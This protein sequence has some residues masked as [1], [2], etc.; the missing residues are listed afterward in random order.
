MDSNQVDMAEYFGLLGD[1]VRLLILSQLAERPHNVGDL[2]EAAGVS[3]PTASHHLGKLRAAF[4][5][6][7][8]RDGR[9][10]IYSTNPEIL[11]DMRSY[12]LYLCGEDTRQAPIPEVV[13]NEE[14]DIPEVNGQGS[15]S[16]LRDAVPEE[17]EPKTTASCETLEVRLAGVAD[18]EPGIETQS[19]ASETPEPTDTEGEGEG[20]GSGLARLGGL[21]D[22]EDAAHEH[23]PIPDNV[24]WLRKAIG[25]LVVGGVYLLGG[26]PGIGKST[27]ALQ[28][29]LG[30]GLRDEHSL[31]IL[32]EQSAGEVGKRA[33]HLTKGWQ[34]EDQTRA[35]QAV[36]PEEGVYSL[37]ALPDFLVHQILSPNGKY[38]G[39]RLVVVDSVQG[40]GISSRSTKTY[41]HVYEFSR[42]C[43]GAGI[44]VV[45]VCHVTKAGQIAGPKGLEHN[46]DCVVVMRKAMSYRPLFVPKNRFGPAVLQPLLLEMSRDTGALRES[47]HAES[48]STA[49]R[50]FLTKDAPAL[51]E[52]QAAVSLPAYGSRGKIIA[53]G[54]P[55]KEIEQIVSCVNQLPDMSLD[56][57][58]Y[59]LNCR[60][61][62]DGIYRSTLG[63]PLA[64]ALIAS[65]IQQSIPRRNLYIGEIDLLRHVRQAP[66]R[67]IDELLALLND[68]EDPLP[69]RVFLPQAD[70]QRVLQEMP[71]GK[72]DIVGCAQ[73]EDAVYS[74]WPDLK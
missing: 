73:L 29:G 1:E 45:L 37:E 28:L 57:L 14:P 18:A 34:K 17:D 6:K 56:D 16:L 13:Q 24:S 46:V 10:V 39:V 33:R 51:P 59:S 50:S 36:L 70:A 5:V 15:G 22:V 63:L 66:P 3:Q 8:T 21:L 35:L 74:T 7:D 68:D 71:S 9:R 26:E 58:S 31:L 61:P 2:C 42:K 53:P 25:S 41:K 69:L 62:G 11:C 32:T 27:L 44:T 64:M 47:Q 40:H 52:V 23:I 43:K 60:L 72:A 67:L 49:A 19:A 30:L 54:L 55:N 4:L 20:A 38:R 65:Y 12:L 48:V